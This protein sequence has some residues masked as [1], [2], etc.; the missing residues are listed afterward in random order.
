MKT[1]NRGEANRRFISELNNIV[2]TKA[3]FRSIY[4]NRIIE[5]WFK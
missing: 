1:R 2:L 4:T 3:S 5:I